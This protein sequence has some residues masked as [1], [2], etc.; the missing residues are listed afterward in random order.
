MVIDEPAEIDRVRCPDVSDL[1]DSSLGQMRREGTV[2]AV[3]AGQVKTTSGLMYEIV[4][5]GTGP[6]AKRGHT[7][8]IHETLTLPDGKLLF[9]SRKNN[10][11]VTF[12]LGGNQV[13]LGLPSRAPPIACASPDSDSDEQVIF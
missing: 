1:P 6:I 12:V 3:P 13:I 10:R 4:V 5:K 9:T 11:P 8:R 2:A 7:V